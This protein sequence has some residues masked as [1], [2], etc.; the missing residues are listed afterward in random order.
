MRRRDCAEIQQGIGSSTVTGIGTGVHIWIPRT[1]SSG[2]SSPQTLDDLIADLF[3]NSEEG[4]AFVASDTSEVFTDQAGTTAAELDDP[5]GNWGDKSGN[6]ND[7]DTGNSSRKPVWRQTGGGVY[8]LDFDGVD[9]RLTK[10]G[11]VLSTATAMTIVAGA[12]LDDDTGYG[13][14]FRTLCAQNTA[15]TPGEWWTFVW[16]TAGA[17]GR[18]GIRTSG[19][20]GVVSDLNDD[21]LG[22]FSVLSTVR[23]ATSAEVFQNNVSLGD[24]TGLSAFEP[25]SGETFRVGHDNGSDRWFNGKISV[26]ICVGRTLTTTESDDLHGFVGDEIEV[27]I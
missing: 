26:L 20:D 18:L 4:F 9:D 15:Y 11:G 24:A 16:D 17:T 27:S 8:Y 19:G 14:T 22:Q 12:A 2:G 6:S 25:A 1:R 3:A 10:S 7:V 5:I 23:D 13:T 21:T